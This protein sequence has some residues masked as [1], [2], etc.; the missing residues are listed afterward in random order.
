MMNSFTNIFMKSDIQFYVY[1]NNSNN[2]VDNIVIV[3]DVLSHP[4]FDC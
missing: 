2:T 1:E 3:S 4:E